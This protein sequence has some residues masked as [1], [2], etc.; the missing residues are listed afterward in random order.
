MANI[1]KVKRSATPAKVPTTSDLELGEIAVNTYD[2]K[3]YIKKDDGTVS[4]VEIGGASGSGDVVG[5]SSATDNAVARFNTTTGKL[6]QNSAVTLDDNGNLASVNSVGFDTTPSTLP[7][8]EGSLYW[9]TSDGTLDLVMRGGNVVQQIGEEQYYTVRNETGSTIANGI[10]VMVNGVTAGSGRITV[11]PAIANGSIDELKFIGLTTESITSGINGYVTSFGYVRGLDTRGTPYG[12]TWAEGDIIYVSP[13]TAGYLTNVEP[14]APNIKIVVAIVITR[15]QTSG[16]LLVRP[17]AYP[18]ITHLSDVNISS[19]TSGNTLIYDAVQGRWEN[20]NLTDGTGI[21]ITEGA[22]SITVANTSPMTYPGAGIPNSTGSAW[23]TSYNVTGTGNVVLSASPTITGTLTAPVINASGNLTLIP[24]GTAS[25]GNTRINSSQLYIQLSK[26]IG[27]TAY[28]SGLR[29]SASCAADG[30]ETYLFDAPYTTDRSSLVRFS[31][32]NTYLQ[33]MNTNDAMGIQYGATFNTGYMGLVST[34]ATFPSG[35]NTN[36]Y[37][38]GMAGSTFAQGSIIPA[39]GGSPNFRNIL[40]DG[41]G[42]LICG[43]LNTGLGGTSTISATNFLKI[44]HTTPSTSTTSGALQVAGGVGIAGALN[45]A[46]DSKING[47]T[48]GKG[49][50]NIS[51]NMA[52]GAGSLTNALTTGIRNVGIGGN[53][54]NSLTS[55][56]DN[57]AIGY[58]AGNITS[59]SGNFALGNEALAGEFGSITG[60]NNFALGYRAL[61]RLTTGNQN[62][63][64]GAGAMQ[65]GATVITGSHNIA[66]GYENSQRI[67]TGSGN[68]V[69]GNYA[70]GSLTTG[71]SNI[72]IGYGNGGNISTGI[73]NVGIG[74]G[75]LGNTTTSSYN[76]AVGISALEGNTTGD[77]SVAIGYQALKNTTTFV[78]AFGTITGGSGYTPASGTVTY[79]NVQLTYSGTGTAVAAGGTYPTANIT[80]TDGAVTNVVLVNTGSRFKDTT[81]VMTCLASSIGGTV[82]TPFTVGVASLAFAT[83]NTAVGFNS[84]V[85]N[86]SGLFNTALGNS[87]LGNNSNS[88]ENTGIGYFALNANTTGQVNTAVGSYALGRNTTGFNN[89]A[90]GR[91]TLLEN[92]T[93][94]QNTAIGLAAFLNHTTGDGNTVIGS[95]A[96]VKYADGTTNATTGGNSVYLGAFTRRTA[97]DTN[98]LVLGYGAISLG[99]NT[100][101]IG[102]LN[103][104]STKIFGTLE[105]TGDATING[106]RVGRGAGNIASNLV[107]GTQALNANTTGTNNVAFGTDALLLNQTGNNNIAIGAN[108]LDSIVSTGDNVAIGQN[109]LGVNVGSENVAIGQLALS[110]YTG[111]QNV[112]IGRAALLACTIGDNNTAIGRDAGV[113][114]TQGANNTCIGGSSGGGLTTGSNNILI[115][116][117]TSVAA[118][119]NTH[120]IVI[121]VEAV[122]L[123][124]NTTVI[125]KANSAFNSYIYGALNAG[126]NMTVSSTTNLATGATASAQTNTIN[127]GTGGLASSITNIAIGSTLGTSTTTFNGSVGI[128]TSSP[129]SVLHISSATNSSLLRLEQTGANNQATINF[130]TTGGTA[131]YSLDQSGNAVFRVSQSGLYFDNFGAT[132][133]IIFRTNGVNQRM[134]IDPNGYV[135]INTLTASSAVF[136]D[137][138]K[139][140]VSVATTGTG[141]VVLAASPTITGT[142]T[143]ATITASADATVNGVRVGRGP[144]NIDTN[145]VVGYQALN[146]NTTGASN[147]ALG[148]QAALVNT[149][150]ADNMAIGKLT[151]RN[152]ST[153]SS[154]VAVG[155]AA[156]YNN[157]GSSNVAIGTNALNSGAAISNNTAIGHEALKANTAGSS[158]AIGYQAFVANTSGGSNTGLG[159]SV[160]TQ[161][162]TDTNSIVIGS[163]AVGIGS[164]TTVIGN[165]STTKTKLF[166]TLETTGDATINSITVGRGSAQ[167][168]TNLAVGASALSSVRMSTAT[169]QNVGIGLNALSSLKSTATQINYYNDNGSSLFQ[170]EFLYSV[171]TTLDTRYGGATLEAGGEYPIINIFIFDD[172]D[173]GFYIG[174]WELVNG[175]SKFPATGTVFFKAQFT[176]PAG[177]VIDYTFYNIAVSTGSGNTAIG[178]NAGS[179]SSVGANSIYIGYG[180]NPVASLTSYRTN[181]IVIGAGVT[182]NGS[183]TTVIGSSGSNTYI[184]QT[185]ALYTGGI[186]ATSIVITNSFDASNTVFNTSSNANFNIRGTST[187]ESYISSA[188]T[189][190]T[191]LIGGTSTSTSAGTITLGQATGTSTVNIATGSVANARTKTVNIGTNGLSG[192]T[193]NITVGT[194]NSGSTSSIRFNGNIGVNTAATTTYQLQVNGAF[195][196]TTKSFVI[197]HPTKAGKQ[198]RYGSL[199]GPENGVYVRGRLKGNK[200]ELPEYWTKLVDPDSITVNL[201]PIGKSQ[202][203]YVEDIIDNTIIVGNKSAEINCFYVVYGERIDVD[204]LEVEID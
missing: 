188:Q 181:E 63:A 164:N 81:T 152:N 32:P 20:A 15:N 126:T 89:V 170:E 52:I 48:V 173:G 64:M 28:T 135:S 69:F 76:T 163:S 196:A 201:T 77:G 34:G 24:S 35:A 105:A 38:Y 178:Y 157:T 61:N 43:S 171:Q 146:G 203:L 129:N 22:G 193:T 148:Y 143:A 111:N 175:G 183:N 102:N 49:A 5:P 72:I 101:V 139:N 182:G 19:P 11:T 147:V 3:M 59:G 79:N 2:G 165:S 74:Q 127:V 98:T 73:F 125:G 36:R 57:L 58:S 132:G 185:A 106:V 8:A 122:G 84:L 97:A 95:E 60:S 4:V 75:T 55:G 159:N 167:V 6:I 80:V 137:A 71:S 44:N 155:N 168:S 31:F 191:L 202:N 16:V 172:G 39:T 134:V 50:A 142:L 87:A 192:S 116:R 82:T 65:G 109:A 66:M 145:T 100:T 198:L 151:L 86:V 33:V 83:G 93:G 130:S 23:G 40:D 154:N 144:G 1:V 78:N 42:N 121:G 169:N 70:G 162:I 90:M 46:S 187:G 30:T 99:A 96:G 156:L 197:P 13:T 118:A 161:S 10:P 199:E 51:T 123:G 177:Q 104:L 160:T 194:S 119:A 62:I 174:S 115:G 91:Y 113:Q 120:S 54:L 186:N 179:Q 108:A 166:G 12:E 88:R 41:S 140:L 149:T 25:A 112:A 103:T 204:K 29:M 14:T 128:G 184:S 195:A 21:S 53:N 107:M 68:L 26:F 67:T 200:I 56:S 176:T 7:T 133:G 180:A 85:N 17:T 94:S 110:A 37:L 131:Q 92:T 27:G 117:S 47:I 153:G 138:S 114:I 9:N 190:G 124:S 18:H 150:G 136:T 158:V 141:N 189:S 45:V